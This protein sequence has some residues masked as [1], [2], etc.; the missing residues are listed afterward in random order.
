MYLDGRF[1]GSEALLPTTPSLGA[2]PFSRALQRNVHVSSRLFACVPSLEHGVL[3]PPVPAVLYNP[4]RVISVPSSPIPPVGDVAI[5]V[6]EVQ[7]T[8]EEEHDSMEW[9]SLYFIK[10]YILTFDSDHGRRRH[11]L[12]PGQQFFPAP[13]ISPSSALHTSGSPST[14][15][16]LSAPHNYHFY[17]NNGTIDVVVGPFRTSSGHVGCVE[18]LTFSVLPRLNLAECRSI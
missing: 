9:P 16:R 5:S 1:C 12:L 7:L 14:M 3:R 6:Q 11:L 13:R 18:D 15:P 10:Q 2:M 4:P 8:P 17:P